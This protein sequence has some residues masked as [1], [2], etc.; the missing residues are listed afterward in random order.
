MRALNRLTAVGIRAAVPGEKLHD[1]GGLYA[2]KGENGGG[3]WVLRLTLHGRQRYMGLGSLND[4]SLKEA[5]AAAERWRAVAR[6]GRDP[7]KERARLRREASRPETTLA[8]IAHDAF[9]ARKAELKG[10]GRA[11][12]WFSP[13]EL[14]ILPRFG[15][16]PVEEI[17]QRDIRDAL[18]PIWHAKAATAKK[19]LDR[20][21]IV[22]R[23][24]AALGLEVDLQATQK[25][26]ALLGAP[27]HVARN[28]PALPWAEVP[29]F[30]A[31]LDEGL[32]SHLALKL[33]ILTGLR[34]DAVRHAR[35]TDIEG[36]LWTVPAEYLKGR[37]GRT[38]PFRLPLS[39]EARR[40]IGV[41]ALTARE[42]WLFPGARKGVISDATMSRMME[43]RGLEAR[44]HGFRAC[45]RTWIAEATDTPW[46][47]AETA[48]QHV[49]GGATQRAYQRSDHLEQRRALM[50]RWARFCTGAEEA[51]TVVR[52][53]A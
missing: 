2:I 11:G 27:R 21:G 24:A 40:V 41:A 39:T 52:L 5:R 4:V 43:R 36:D 48:I 1:G 44:P 14:H 47:V 37:K 3:K 19:A 35:L 7:I 45:I 38:L 33:V 53:R 6:E 30:Y 50:E 51:G 8:A 31:S 46:E 13:V 9:E 29:A 26:R 17:D 34:S 12:R 23:H 49:V 25:A 10:D 28:I 20:L 22:L 42:G 18:A 16:I 32:V 15:K